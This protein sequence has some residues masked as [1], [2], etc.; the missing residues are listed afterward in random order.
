VNQFTDENKDEQ[1]LQAEPSIADSALKK[2]IG[3]KNDDHHDDDHHGH[4]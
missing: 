3:E 2:Q 1:L 4:H